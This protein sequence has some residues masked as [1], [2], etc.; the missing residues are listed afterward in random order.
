MRRIDREIKTFEEIVEVVERCD[1]VRLGMA[2]E[3]YPYVVPLS[4]GYEVV[5]E[6]L[7]I[8]VHG[9]KEGL[10]HELLAKCNR[11]CI[12]ADIC[13]GFVETER[14]ITTL[15]ESVIGFGIAQKVEGKEARKGLELILAHSG[16]PNEPLSD[17]A[18]SITGVYKIMLDK[19]SGKRNR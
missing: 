19:L 9:A 4:F 11:V 6:K 2:G 13:H 14:G 3:I 17:K 12:E 18:L 15:Y 5:N 7:M 1:T 16:F 10:K 8:Y